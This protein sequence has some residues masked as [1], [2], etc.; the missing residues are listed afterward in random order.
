MAALLN[1]AHGH[2]QAGQAGQAEQLCQQILAAW[3][4]QADAL[5]LLGL[6]AHTYGNAPLA[7]Q[8]MRQ[9]CQSPRAPALFFRNLTEMCRQQGLLEEGEKAGRQAVA[10]EPTDGDGWNNLG[11]VLQEQGRLD[12]SLECLQQALTLQP[13]NPQ[14]LT[15]L[16]NTCARAGRTEEGMGY[17][18]Q[19]LELNPHHLQAN[20]NLAAL[21]IAQGQLDVAYRHAQAALEEEPQFADAYLHLADIEMQRGNPGAALRWINTLLSFAPQ[22]QDALVGQARLLQ[23]LGQ[24]REALAAARQAVFLYPE[25]CAAHFFLGA[26]LHTQQAFDE[27]AH[28]YRRA[29]ALPGPQ[30]AEA[31]LAL[32]RLYQDGGQP[33]AEKEALAQVRQRFPDSPPVLIAHRDAKTYGVQDPDLAV[34]NQWLAQ[35]GLQDNLGAALH[36]TLGKAAL[37]QGDIPLAATHWAQANQRMLGHSRYNGDQARGQLAA[38]RAAFAAPLQA[39]P[40][41]PSSSRPLFLVGMSGDGQNWVEHILAAHSQ[42]GQGG[43]MSHWAQQVEARGPY[44]QALAPLGDGDWAALGQAYLEA[45]AS[46]Q[47]QASRLTDRSEGNFL[48]LGPIARALP[49]ARILHCHR[50][51]L[52]TCL[53]CYGNPT[54]GNPLAIYTPE[55]L[56]RY[57]RAY[58]ELMAHW[59][60][61]LPPGQMLDVDVDALAADP[62]GQLPGLLAFLELPWEASCLER[63]QTLPAPAPIPN[64]DA[65]GPYLTPLWEALGEEVQR[66]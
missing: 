64:R 18:Q 48:Y 11:I 66:S 65:L 60:A 29:T 13:T 62:A 4:G 51:P 55:E 16:G 19:A 3:P 21:A 8:Y 32:A 6:M 17:Y 43:A 63:A 42:V 35:P 34:M 28:A 22:H 47:A 30:A 7:L 39:A 52:D 20:A 31:W 5:H 54:G 26:I 2:W 33:A 14:V 24:D 1:R 36:A 50:A 46:R 15:N 23:S 10:L 58:Q 61:V 56:G 45:T 12:A 40:Q 49:G 59:Q 57:Y 44:P 38:I 41:A 27:A 9:A 37:D 25:S 53:S